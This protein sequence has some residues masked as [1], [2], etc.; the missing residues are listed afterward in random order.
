MKITVDESLFIQR[1]REYG[2]GDQF[3]L[4]GLRELFAF[5]ESLEA[6]TGESMELDVIGLCCDFREISIDEIERETGC[7]SLE[8]L[9]DE[10]IVIQVD[11]ETIIYH[12][13]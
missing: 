3:S 12:A 8:D 7:K 1:F 4:R 9:Q 11:D 5:L 2:R 13:I 10:T 6:D